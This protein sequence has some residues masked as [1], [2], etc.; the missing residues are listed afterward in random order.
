MAKQLA[1]NVVVLDDQQ[2]PVVLTAGQE[3]PA[4]FADQVGDHCFDEQGTSAEK[5]ARPRARAAK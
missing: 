4:E 1:V 5:P 3:V 2:N